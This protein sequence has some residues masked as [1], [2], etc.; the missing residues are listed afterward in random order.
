MFDLDTFRKSLSTQWLA[1]SQL[2]FEELE[3]TNTYLKKLP[4][5]QI[6]HGLLCITDHQTKGRGQYERPWV[7]PPGKNLTF[8]LAFTPLEEGRLHVLTLACARAAVDQIKDVTGLEA[9][10]KW[11]NDVIIEGKKVGGILTE[12]IFNGNHLDRVLIGIGLNINQEDFPNEELRKKAISLRQLTNKNISREQFLCGFLSRIEYEYG[13]WHKKNST[14]LKNINQK[15]VG[16][17]KW[18]KLNVNGDELGQKYK[19]LGVNEKG[20]LVVIDSEGGIET[21]SY[22]QI[23][24]ITD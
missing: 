14:L 15:I 16:Y 10:I 19:L 12:A 7:V 6:S 3:S 9:Q 11:P 4:P 24:L 23:R 22:E 8:T 1:Q 5:G 13:R 17:G 18:I 20:Q 21:F 2:Y